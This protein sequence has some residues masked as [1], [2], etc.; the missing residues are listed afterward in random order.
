MQIELSQFYIRLGSIGLILL[1]GF[2]LG[3]FKLI[4]KKTNQEI[5]NL[6]LV[7]FMPASLFVAFPSNRGG[8]A[9]K[10]VPKSSEDRTA[11]C[12]FPLEWA[13]LNDEKLE[14]VSGIEGLKFCHTGRFIVSCRDINC[15]YQVLD[16][17]CQ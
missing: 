17:L 14:E 3:K 6:L 15:V 8:F 7:I 5:T 13:G 16:K 4:T 12:E 10:T 1:L 2:F 9:I 11:R